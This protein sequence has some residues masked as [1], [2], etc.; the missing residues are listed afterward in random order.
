VFAL[1]PFAL[2]IPTFYPVIVVPLYFAELVERACWAPDGQEW[3][4]FRDNFYAKVVVQSSRVLW[5]AIWI[6]WP[7]PTV[8]LEPLHE[9][10]EYHHER[11]SDLKQRQH[12][13]SEALD[14]TKV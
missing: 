10:A 14:E 8:Q 3:Q 9:Q 13:T 11:A 2:S 1:G 6:F 5:R 12:L 7:L 4:Y